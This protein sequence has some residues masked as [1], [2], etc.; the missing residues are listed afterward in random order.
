MFNSFCGC[1]SVIP[2]DADLA[3]FI[4]FLFY[5]YIWCVRIY[6]LIFLIVIIFFVIFL[7][8]S[9]LKKKKN[10]QESQKFL[11][12]DIIGDDYGS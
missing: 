2:G 1:L 12:V 3:D 5:K 11:D 8:L 4:M 7:F 10:I 9:S 6:I